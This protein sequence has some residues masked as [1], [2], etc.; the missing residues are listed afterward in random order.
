MGIYGKFFHEITVR[1]IQLDRIGQMGV[2][3]NEY[4]NGFSFPKPKGFLE[5]KKE[6]YPFH[7]SGRMIDCSL[8]IQI[9]ASD[10]KNVNAVIGSMLLFKPWHY[11]VVFEGK[12]PDL[13]QFLVAEPAPDLF[14]YVPHYFPL[15]DGR[16]PNPSSTDISLYLERVR[17]GHPDGFSWQGTECANFSY[18]EFSEK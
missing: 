15:L 5:A 6:L 8:D 17:S 16:S 18:I 14:Q 10:P 1:A 13:S 9:E 7:N 2:S 4:Y 12:I 3:A 11:A